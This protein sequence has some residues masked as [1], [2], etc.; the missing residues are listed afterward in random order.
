MMSRQREP[1]GLSGNDHG[2]TSGSQPLSYSYEMSVRAISFAAT[3]W[4]SLATPVGAVAARC[5]AGDTW[6]LAVG[7]ERA[8]AR[9]DWPR[10]ATIYGCATRSSNDPA[11]A[12]R[13]TRT[14][15]EN[16]QFHAAVDAARRWLA[17]VP[18]SEVARRHLATGLLRLYD[19]EAA[20]AQ[21]ALL[22][23]TSYQD[24]ARGYLVLLGILAAEPNETGAALIMERLAARDAG[25]AEAQYAASVLWQRA[26]HG[27]KALAAAD[28]A[29]ALRSGW[30]Q[31]ELARVRALATQG[32]IDE[33]L[34]LSSELAADGDLFS[35]ISHAWLLLGNDRRDEAAAL[36]EELRRAGGAAAGDALGGLAAIAIDER[37]FDDATRLLNEASRD[38]QQAE[39]L[40][41]NLAQIAEE[42]DEPAPAARQYQRITTGTRAVAAQLRAFRLWRELGAPE[43]AELLIDDFL[44]MSA[45]ETSNVVAG[46]A[47][48]LVDED[49]GGSAIALI[50]RALL[51]MPDDNLLL[52]RAFLLERQE[53]VPEAIADLRKVLARRP[54]DPEAQNALGYTLVDRTRSIREGHRLIA[55]ALEAKPDSYAIQDSMGWAL[56][57]MGRL[58][59]GRGWL[60]QAWKRS[61]DP[62]V[63][64]HLGETL[65]MQG[66]IEDAW[67]IWDEALAANPDSRPLKRAIERHPR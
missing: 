55:R 49:R 53:R 33:A 4:L 63:A 41:W 18:D 52:A 43:R 35:K 59:E 65:W 58:D 7:A 34:Q 48:L 10:A 40:Q 24:R 27:G 5:P 12:E 46:V 16:R 13:A 17:L 6:T 29:L 14:A 26:E 39:T 15:Y 42:R 44:A 60:E 20:A 30:R 23:D 54:Q 37:R 50:D 11:L 36:F 8:L 21:F 62:E 38:P 25:L 56:V 2:S 19:D 32:R 1:A 51:H 67:R 3:M 22:L 61:Q 28:R 57:R 47:A 64:A 9:A 31:A 45:A 66:R